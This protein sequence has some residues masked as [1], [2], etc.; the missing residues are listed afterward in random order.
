[1]TIEDPIEYLDRDKRSVVNQREVAVDTCRS[2]GAAGR[3]AAG[4]G[5]PPVGEMR[6][7]ETV[8][9]ALLAAEN[10]HLCSRRCTRWTPRRRSSVSSRCSRRISSAGAHA[11]R[12]A[13]S[14]R[15]FAAPVP[16]ADS[17]AGSPP[18]EM[19]IATPRH[20]RL[21]RRQSQ[22][23]SPIHARSPPA[24]RSTGCGV[25]QS[26]LGDRPEASSPTRRRRGR[27]R[28]RT[29]S[30]EGSRGIVTTVKLAR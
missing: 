15:S 6:D 24:R 2:P 29:N 14:R 7:P 13:C 8:E 9:T 16:R 30:A 4:P 17:R 28:T 22:D 23:R 26:M 21:D 25:D 5:R 20:P 19:M 3:A 1:M 18:V 27:P 12:V 10:G 11:A